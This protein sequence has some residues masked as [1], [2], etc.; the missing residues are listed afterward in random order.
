MATLKYSSR[1]CVASKYENKIRI[2]SFDNKNLTERT[3]WSY[4]SD[5]NTMEDKAYKQLDALNSGT[6]ITMSNLKSNI[7]PHKFSDKKNKHIDFLN[8]Q[9]RTKKFL[10][11]VFEKMIN[12]KNLIFSWA[13]KSTD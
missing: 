9:V 10:G 11:I 1:V 5:A 7:N 2:R 6:M 13:R 4:S 12:E 8:H 3:Q